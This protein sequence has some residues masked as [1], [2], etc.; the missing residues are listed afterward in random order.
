MLNKKKQKADP[1]WGK[2]AYQWHHPE[3]IIENLQQ[4]Q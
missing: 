4:A 1:E 3:N 2:K